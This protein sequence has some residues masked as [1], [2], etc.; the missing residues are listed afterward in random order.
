MLA[1]DDV[2]AIAIDSIFTPIR[3][4]KYEIEDYRIEQK[5]DYEKLVIEIVTDGSIAPK[6]A[7]KEAALILIQHLVLFSDV[8]KIML[9]TTDAEGIV[10]FDE[11]VLY[12]SY[13]LNTK[14]SDLNFTIR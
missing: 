12:M 6:E 9:E 10:E 2:Q 8:N 13:L 3:N 7:L 14:M 11:E 5:T 4:V 1:T